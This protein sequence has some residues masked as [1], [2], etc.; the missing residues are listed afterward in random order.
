MYTNRDLRYI[1][2]DVLNIMSVIMEY[3]F[4]T[5][6]SIVWDRATAHSNLIHLAAIKL[7]FENQD[8]KKD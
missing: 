3:C 1:S 6:S 7:L 2:F 4:G 5:L 8:P